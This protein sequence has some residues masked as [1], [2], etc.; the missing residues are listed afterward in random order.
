M[1]RELS[2]AE[3][4]AQVAQALR[5]LADRF[6]AREFVPFDFSL[7]N[8]MQSEEDWDTGTV[9]TKPTG[10]RNLGMRF[11]VKTS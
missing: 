5:Q 9:R 1:S 3:R 6:E 10:F 8:E 11:R 2:E 4:C 7:E